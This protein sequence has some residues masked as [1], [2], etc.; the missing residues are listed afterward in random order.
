M[1]AEVVGGLGLFLMGMWLMSD[2]LRLAGGD[3]L[4]TIL[5][6]WTSSPLRGLLTG[7]GV[8]GLVQS[9]SAVGMAIIGF[10][11]AGLLTL[12]QAIWVIYGAGVGATF[13]GWIVELLGFRLDVAAF[14]MPA[15]GLGMALKF[16]AS[17]RTAAL[18]QAI[19]G[20][21]VL[22]LGVAAL[23]AGFVGAAE[24]MTLPSLDGDGPLTLLAYLGVGLVLT[25]LLQSSSAFLVVAMSAL[26]SGLV[27][28]PQAAAMMLGASIGTTSDAILAA[29]G[30]TPTAKRV[31]SAHVIFACLS[32]AVG[33]VLLRPLLAGIDAALGAM[34]R[35]TGGSLTLVAYYTGV[36]LLGVLAIW[37]VTP[38]IERFLERRFAIPEAEA[39]RPRFLD[40]NVLKVPAL[41]LE[42]ARRETGR[43]RD[44]A[45]AALAAWFAAPEAPGAADRLADAS[46]AA[47]ALADRIAGFLSAL[48][49][50]GLAPSDVARIQTLTR[51]LQHYLAALHDAES[52]A[53]TLAEARAASPE[54]A[55]L[56]AAVAAAI[57]RPETMGAALEDRLQ[58]EREMLKEGMLVKVADGRL[59]L[60]ALDA[61][62]RGMNAELRLLR[63]L[64]KGRAYLAA[65]AGR[66][67]ARGDAAR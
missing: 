45:E 54:R 37:P 4:K 55:E 56:H 66:P 29:I 60:D 43:L 44:L 8:T 32:A 50:S 35:P 7:V 24:R 22:F 1:I 31:A 2:G 12:D 28:L 15:I 57:A 34:G 19:A 27:G 58:A 38:A 46:T 63:H 9:S 13:I 64:R 33:F 67:C 30:A 62:L 18:G 20:F 5:G 6:R 42:A 3:A 40:R 52:A 59:P 36:K 53:G 17:G 11:N 23:E 21:G 26:A 16:A 48:S 41:A 49:A 61:H 51:T 65:L 14:A 39:A 10:A 47:H 25:A